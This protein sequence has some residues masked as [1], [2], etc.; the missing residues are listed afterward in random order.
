MN[1]ILEEESEGR[2]RDNK[3]LLT[4]MELSL[5]SQIACDYKLCHLIVNK[6]TRIGA[7]TMRR[8]SF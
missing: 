7:L 4:Q 6:E 1:Q 5:L 3:C 2:A 8:I